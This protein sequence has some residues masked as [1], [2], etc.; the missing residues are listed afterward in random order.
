MFFVDKNNESDTFQA[1]HYQL[2]YLLE[3][4]LFLYVKVFEYIVK[5]SLLDIKPNEFPDLQK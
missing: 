2:D 1:F 5:D 4:H 3:C